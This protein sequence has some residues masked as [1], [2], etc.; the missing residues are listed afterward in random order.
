MIRFLFILL[1]GALPAV[2]EPQARI[3][4]PAPGAPAVGETVIE[5][6]TTLAAVD[7]IE[8]RV[9]GRLAGVLRTPPYRLPFDFGPEP[10]AHRIEAEVFAGRYAE[11]A[12]S[13]SWP[14][15]GPPRQ[16]RKPIGGGYASFVSAHGKGFT[17]EQR[18]NQEVAAAYDLTSVQ[19]V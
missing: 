5:V 10:R 8:I 4:S 14:K 3:V 17:I 12:V 19:E 1:L 9:D 15:D 18:R 16:W 13:F 6:E 11:R 2:A 7:R